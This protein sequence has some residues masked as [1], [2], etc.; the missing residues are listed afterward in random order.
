MGW[1][2]ELEGVPP[3]IFHVAPTDPVDAT[4]ACP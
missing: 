4:N 1:P 2:P 3:S